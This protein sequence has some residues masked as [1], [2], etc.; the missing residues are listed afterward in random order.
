MRAPGAQANLKHGTKLGRT[1]CY[2]PHPTVPFLAQRIFMLMPLRSR[3]PFALVCRDAA[4]VARAFWS[5]SEFEQVSTPPTY[6]AQG[7]LPPAV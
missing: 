6:S 7:T 5:T 1:L 2:S 4:E 3:G